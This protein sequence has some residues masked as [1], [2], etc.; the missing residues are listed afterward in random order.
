MPRMSPASR[1][2]KTP[3]PGSA[4]AALGYHDFRRM[5]FSNFLSGIGT[6]MQ[7]VVLPAYVYSRTGKASMVALFSFSQMGPLLLLSIPAGVIAD[8]FDRRKFLI[9]TQMVQLVFSVLLGVFAQQDAHMAALFLANLGVGVGNAFN[10]PAFSAVLPSLVR[11]EDLG[12]SIALSS[13]SV[14]LSRVIGPIVVVA[15]ANIGVSTPGMFYINAA[16]YLFVIFTLLNIT[17]APHKSPEEKGW[18]SFTLGVRTA[19][20]RPVIGR[21]LLTMFSFS[22]I[23]LTFVGLFP[24]VAK[25]TFH[26]A[27]K[28]LTYKWLYATWGFGSMLGALAIGTILATEDKRKS[29]RRGFLLFGCALTLFAL[30]PSVPLAFVTGF[31]L[32]TTYFSTT[33]A[34]MTVLQS[35]LETNIRARVLAL[36][37]MAFGGTIPIGNL[38]FGPLMDRIGSRPVLFVGAAWALFLSRWCNIERLDRQA[39]EDASLLAARTLDD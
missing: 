9:V 36:W 28:S 16:T 29:A 7:N 25:L 23:S 30:S 18:R 24:A 27:P 17:L 3:T 8:K 11:P 6:W 2:K 20:E 26:I 10:A 33:T 4:R 38:V 21:I 13:V 37:F 31:L 12:G 34:L 32:G 1:Q 39:A 14:N 19:R 5:W 35:R 22:L 15:L